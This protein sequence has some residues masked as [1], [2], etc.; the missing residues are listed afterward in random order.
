MPRSIKSSRAND[1]LL[2]AG[3][4]TIILENINNAEGHSW[5]FFTE[6][7]VNVGICRCADNGKIEDPIGRA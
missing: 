4:V 7:E 3:F 2:S 6:Y 1:R 5:A